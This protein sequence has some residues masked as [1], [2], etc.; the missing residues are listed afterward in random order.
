MTVIDRVGGHL[1]RGRVTVE[2]DEIQATV[3]RYRPEPYYGTH[4]MLQVDDVR[5]G[6]ELLRNLTPHVDSAADWWQTDEPWIA[7][8]ITYSGLVAL[9]VPED[10]LQSFPEAFR[11]GMAARA[12]KL[13]DRGVNDPNHWEPEFG[14]GVIHVGVSVFSDSQETWRR[15]MDTARQHYEGRPGLTVVSAQDF[16]AQP[17]D[18]NP[19]GY[20]DSIG[21]PAIEGS[22]VEPLPGQGPAIK[23]GEFILG[24]PGRGRRAASGATARRAGPK[25]HIRRVAQVPVAG[26]GVQ[27]LPAG[28]RSDRRRARAARGEAGGAL[29]QRRPTDARAGPRRSGARRRPATKQRLHLRR[30]SGWPT[31]ATRLPHAADESTRHQD[32]APR[33]REASIASS[34][35]ARPSELPTT[36]TPSRN[37]TTKPPAVCTSS[38]SARRR[39][40]RWSSCS[41]SGSTTAT[42]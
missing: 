3:L 26:W 24:Y 21:Q 14:S 19:L 4:V 30:R 23:A 36:R 18:L 27:P 22:G 13:L 20:R 29:A 25:R 41:R 42:S 6:R 31:G 38:S 16:G 8:A 15:T 5:A 28:A 40:R 33:R 9:G 10:S 39:W 34:G 2:L 32:G 7:V 1:P 37:G 11:V 35:A 12:P 17:G